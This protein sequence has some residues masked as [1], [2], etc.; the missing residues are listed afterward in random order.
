MPFCRGGKKQM[1]LAT[2]Q[3]ARAIIL[4]PGILLMMMANPQRRA[5]GHLKL[6]LVNR[7]V[8]LVKRTFVLDTQEWPEGWVEIYNGAYEWLTLILLFRLLDRPCATCPRSLAL[9]ERGQGVTAALC[10]EFLLSWSTSLLGERFLNAFT[11]IL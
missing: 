11:E 9:I 6:R 3:L 10:V 7:G 1:L 8:A 5:I 4:G 2:R